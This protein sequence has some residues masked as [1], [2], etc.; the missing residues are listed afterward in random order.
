MHNMP[1]RCRYIMTSTHKQRSAANSN[2]EVTWYK[3]NIV[4]LKNIKDVF[5]LIYIWKIYG[6][7][8]KVVSA[9]AWQPLKKQNVYCVYL[10]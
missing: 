10:I 5:H 2:V 8:C 9:I 3:P 6:L 7:S 1:V 4:K